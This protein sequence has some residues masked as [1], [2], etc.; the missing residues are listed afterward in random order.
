M[1]RHQVPN[2]PSVR[3][4][5]VYYHRLM[6]LQSQGETMVSANNLA[7]FIGLD[8]ILVRKDLELTGAVG[9]RGVGYRIDE[10]LEGIRS[11]L[12]WDHWIRAALIGAGALGTAL[13]GFHEFAEYG[14]NICEVFDSS[15]AKIGQKI[16][17]RLIRDVRELPEAIIQNSLEMA[18]IC[19]PAAVAQSVADI[20][21]AGGIRLI[22]N[23]SNT[24]L[25][26][27]DDVIVQR[28]HIAGGFA[29]LS[30]KRKEHIKNQPL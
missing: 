16:F 4:M 17:G 28:E 20:V 6:V 10:L 1:K 24:C 30:R 7:S 21:V 15:H 12:G 29:V 19:V 9:G 3:R 25:A 5:P 26:V 2:S 23:F 22:W 11:Y 13:L 27:P 14:L 18:V 8:T